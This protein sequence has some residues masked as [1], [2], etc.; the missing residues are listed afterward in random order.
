MELSK[1]EASLIKI[2]SEST[3]PAPIPSAP[4]AITVQGEILDPKCYFGVMKPAEGK[5]HKSFAIRCISGGIPP[6]FRQATNNV[7]KPYDYY[8]MLDENGQSINQEILAFAGEDIVINGKT[9][10]FSSWK[11]LYVNS[12]NIKYK[13]N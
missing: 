3:S 1:K 9:N 8:L 13:N 5:I 6:V 2:E 11:V 12:A 4:Q 10:Q 7:E